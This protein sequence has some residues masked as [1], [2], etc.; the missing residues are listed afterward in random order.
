[1]R[2]RYLL[3]WLPRWPKRGWKSARCRE[4]V[5]RTLAG[6]RPSCAATSRTVSKITACPPGWGSLASRTPAPT[7]SVFGVHRLPLHMAGELKSRKDRGRPVLSHEGK[8]QRYGDGHRAD[9]QQMLYG[10]LDM[11]DRRGRVDLAAL[12]HILSAARGR[13]YC[14][15]QMAF[16]N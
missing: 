8:E 7:P 11:L 6:A 9:R 14:E 12:R 16:S 13:A 15:T 5:D 2:T 4:R 1:M 3:G 10:V